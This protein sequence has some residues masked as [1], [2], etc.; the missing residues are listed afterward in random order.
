MEPVL[1]ALVAVTILSLAIGMFALSMNMG[2][3]RVEREI[4]GLGG[5]MIRIAWAPFGR[6]FFF[7]PNGSMLF[8]VVYHDALGRLHDGHCRTDWI[9][10]N[11]WT[12]NRLVDEDDRDGL[13]PRQKRAWL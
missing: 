9:L 11:R 12:E 4:V 5:R 10:G 6:G 1:I 3:R 7:T 13:D 2:R 8:H